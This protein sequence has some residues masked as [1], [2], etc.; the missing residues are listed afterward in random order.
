MLS[1]NG[2]P[3]CDVTFQRIEELLDAGSEEPYSIGPQHHNI[4]NTKDDAEAKS[5]QN[6]DWTKFNEKNEEY[7]DPED[8]PRQYERIRLHHLA[9]RGGLDY[10]VELIGQYFAGMV[11]WIF[12]PSPFVPTSLCGACLGCSSRVF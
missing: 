3:Q 2:S 10:K 9:V 11:A 7:Q 12:F 4:P 6:K 5:K 1:D 8:D